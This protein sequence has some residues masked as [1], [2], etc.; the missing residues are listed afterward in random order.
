MEM[1]HRC[2]HPVLLGAI[3]AVVV[4][5]MAAPALASPAPVSACPPCG[6]GFSRSAATHGLDTGVERGTATVQVHSN[7][8]ATWSVRVIPTNGTVLERLA[9]NRS[10]AR[11][12][13]ADS[14]GTRYGG[15]IDHELLGVSVEDGAFV[16][17]YRTLDV[18]ESGPVETRVLTYFRDAPGAYVY[19]DLGADELTVVAPEGMTVARGFGEVAGDR[20]TAT[21]LPD[22]RDGPFVVFAPD[23]SAGPGLL[24]SLAIAASLWGVVLRNLLYFVVVP[25][26]VLVGGL[27]G[28]RRFIG[29]KRGVDPTRLGGLIAVVGG[30]LVV[31]TLVSEGDAWPVVTGNLLL[32][33]V[34]GVV[35]VGLGA[36]L[37]RPEV[38]R[39]LTGS[40]LVGAG[41]TLGSLAMVFTAELVG[42]GGVQRTLALAA[43]LLPAAVGL[44]WADATEPGSDRLFYGLAVVIVAVLVGTAPLLALGGT[45][46]LLVPILLTAATIAVVVV[47][48]PLY[49]LGTAGATVDGG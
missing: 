37:A 19:T 7:G 41:I 28:A 14:F 18:V 33:G 45:L 20:L 29:P 21:A 13:A 2:R 40:R 22:V 48:V 4:L 46:F 17:R 47:A 3:T 6:D 23:G 15:G 43:G 39:H 26:G 12:V 10:L 35:L 25:G 8:S 24:G 11:E 27:A 49:L 44:G 30:L 5:G 31:G 38:R 36:G 42:S 1:S 32:G 9:A 16:M 34:G